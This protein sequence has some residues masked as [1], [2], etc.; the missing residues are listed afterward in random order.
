MRSMEAEGVINVAGKF[1]VPVKV[2][3]KGAGNDTYAVR[4]GEETN[5]PW[6]H[7]YDK[8]CGE[9]VFRVRD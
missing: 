4:L 2:E 7:E 8:A 9:L 1:G 3:R 5:S 6:H